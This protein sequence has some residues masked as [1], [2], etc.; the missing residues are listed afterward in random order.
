MGRHA[1]AP[2]NPCAGCLNPETGL[3]SIAVNQPA[4]HIQTIELID[5][6]GVLRSHAY[7]VEQLKLTRLTL[8]ELQE[9][10]GVSKR[11]I[12]KIKSGEIVD[13]GVGHIEKLANFFRQNEKAGA[14]V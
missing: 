13:P 3:S 14:R 11:T 7:V 5:A 8:D 9:H 6:D 2:R 4:Q 10:T 12:Q 1:I